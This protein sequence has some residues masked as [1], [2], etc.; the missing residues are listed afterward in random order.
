MS[1][2]TSNRLRALSLEAYE[3]GD[4]STATNMV[5]AA[6]KISPSNEEALALRSALCSTMLCPPPQT[7][8]PEAEPAPTKRRL[9][10]SLSPPNEHMSDSFVY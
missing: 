10:L 2:Q 5:E 1:L 3:Q 4:L 7:E 9:S 8:V 6:L